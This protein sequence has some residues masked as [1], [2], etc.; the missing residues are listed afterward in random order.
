MA[1][2]CLSTIYSLFLATLLIYQLQFE[3]ISHYYL[4][5]EDGEYIDARSSCHNNIHDV[6]QGK[7]GQAEAIVDLFKEYRKNM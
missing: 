1:A 2:V 3:S 7:F 5:E 4:S 6:S